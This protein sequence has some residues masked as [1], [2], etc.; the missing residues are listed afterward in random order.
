MFFI[1]IMITII[2]ISPKGAGLQYPLFL[3][4]QHHLYRSTCASASRLCTADAPSF[5]EMHDQL[6][7]EMTRELIQTRL[8]KLRGEAKIERFGPTGQPLNP[9]Q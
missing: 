5:E 9:A 4:S 7:A 8:E 2:I 3:E 6:T 1:I